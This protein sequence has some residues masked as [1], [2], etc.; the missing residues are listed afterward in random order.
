[1]PDSAET[2]GTRGRIITVVEGF[3]LARLE[4][5]R[6]QRLGTVLRDTEMGAQAAASKWRRSASAAA[7]AQERGVFAI[8]G[9]HR[10]VCAPM[11]RGLQ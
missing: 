1:M 7:L 6:E 5:L 4:E 10:L 3:W 11:Q 2:A 8:T 9:S